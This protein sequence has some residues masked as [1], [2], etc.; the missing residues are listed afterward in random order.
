MRRSLQIAWNGL[1]VELDLATEGRRCDLTDCLDLSLLSFRGGNAGGGRKSCHQP[2]PMIRRDH[3]FEG[4]REEQVEQCVGLHGVV[5]VRMP[6]M[7]SRTSHG[8]L[9]NRS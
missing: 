2:L 8:E 4:P 6:S 1:L 3:V 9:A 5:E 7:S